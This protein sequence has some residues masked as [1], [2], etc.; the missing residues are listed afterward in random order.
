[1]ALAGHVSRSMMERY[2]YTRMEAKRRVV[3]DL[4]GIEC[5]PGWA[6]N[7]TQFLRSEKPDE[8]NALE[9]IW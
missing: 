3:D 7:R 4:S 5:E 9:R 6:Q 2:G 1:M 8:A